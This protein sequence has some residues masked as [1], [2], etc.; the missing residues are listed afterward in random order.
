[1]ESD[2]DESVT[3]V[4]CRVPFPWPLS[5]QTWYRNMGFAP[6]RRCAACRES[7]RRQRDAQRA[8]AQ[9]GETS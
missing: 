4:D 5:E 1:M 7:K 6:P 8:D 9:T 3:C 2:R